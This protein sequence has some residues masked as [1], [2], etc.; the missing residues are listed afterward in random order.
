QKPGRVGSAHHFI[1]H[2]S[3]LTFSAVLPRTYPPKKDKEREKERKR[4]RIYFPIKSAL[5]F[6]PQA[7]RRPSLPHLE[8]HHLCGEFP[9]RLV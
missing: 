9:G 8:L 1:Y 3:P 2:S 6:L 5:H 7:I 4:G